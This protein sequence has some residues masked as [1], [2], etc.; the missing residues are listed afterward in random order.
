MTESEQKMLKILS[1][2]FNAMTQAMVILNKCL[3]NKGALE[4]GQFLAAIKETIN[5]PDAQWDR[6]DYTVLQ[7]LAK[8][9]ERSEQE[10]RIR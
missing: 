9:I 7:M 1:D 4:P 5:H 6:F 2:G 8:E 10:D 3:L